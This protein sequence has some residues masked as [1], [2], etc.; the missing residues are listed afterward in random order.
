MKRKGGT[1]QMG[2][3]VFFF[4]ARFLLRQKK[5]AASEAQIEI[6]YFGVAL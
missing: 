2:E 3:E 6:N 4:S 1:R 5:E